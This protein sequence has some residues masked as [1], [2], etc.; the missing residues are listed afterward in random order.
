MEWYRATYVPHIA[1]DDPSFVREVARA[2]KATTDKHGVYALDKKTNLRVRTIEGGGGLRVR[3][4]GSAGAAQTMMR[5]LCGDD[6]FAAQALAV[7]AEEVAGGVNVHSSDRLF[8]HSLGFV[9]HSSGPLRYTASRYDEMT[10]EYDL[11]RCGRQTTLV[12][13]E[14]R[15]ATEEVEA[16]LKKLEEVDGRGWAATLVREYRMRKINI[17]ERVAEEA[18]SFF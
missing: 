8:V 11:C 6:E 7:R 1:P 5:Q 4:G 14:M 12:A 17:L 13:G 10:R 18:S 16:A 15:G 9:V 3:A 2:T